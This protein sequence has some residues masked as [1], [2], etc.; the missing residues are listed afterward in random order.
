MSY[1]DWEKHY[2]KKSSSGTKNPTAKSKPTQSRK[3]TSSATKKKATIKK[4]VSKKKVAN[5]K[6]KYKPT[7]KKSL[8]MLLIG[9]SLAGV[10]YAG[11]DIV[12]LDSA[13]VSASYT[14]GISVQTKLETSFN[15]TQETQQS[16]IIGNQ[17]AS[18]V[19]LLEYKDYCYIGNYG[20]N[21]Y[22][23]CPEEYVLQIAE[24]SINKLNQLYKSS[25]DMTLLE[26]G[27][28]IPDIITPEL[29]A[30]ICF[31][32]SSYRVE[33]TGGIPLGATRNV[34]ASDRAEGILQQKPD[35]VKD[36]DRYSRMYGGE[37]Y[38][39]E[40]RYN[41][42]TAM[43]MCVTN[44]TRV[45][46][47]YLQKDCDTYKNLGAQS[48]NDDVLLGALIVAYNQGEGSM[49]Y[50]AKTGKLASALARPTSTDKYGL[51]YYKMV[52]DNMEDILEEGYSKQ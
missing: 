10:L 17:V 24:H 16:Y 45:Y 29:L 42:L 28:C 27:E 11:A 15:N 33:C 22:L 50:W 25:G 47:A 40:D 38:S 3:T 21:K 36:A 13:S 8:V 41:P 44:L 1:Q 6:K 4:R 30:A 14:E 19:S 48:S 39:L 32:E 5:R 46:R 51:D 23:F 37:G 18:E 52:M 43:E 7:P 35:F 9:S 20:D 12:K 31:T 49:Q 34:S 2:S 26:N